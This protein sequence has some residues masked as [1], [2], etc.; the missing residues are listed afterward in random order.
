MEGYRFLR[1]GYSRRPEKLRAFQIPLLVSF[2]FITKFSSA[3]IKNIPITDDAAIIKQ[4][5]GEIKMR[6]NGSGYL[7]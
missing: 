5:L 7:V 4:Y 6:L 1:R 3:L 2:D